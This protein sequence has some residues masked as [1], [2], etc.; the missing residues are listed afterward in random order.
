MPG[1][2]EDG[3]RVPPSTA[4]TADA[5]SGVTLESM[6]RQRRGPQARVVL[7]APDV[8]QAMLDDAALQNAIAQ[9]GSLLKRTMRFCLAA[10]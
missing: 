1:E 10:K 7:L 2:P 4:V 3:L 9:F 8:P 6:R 5:A